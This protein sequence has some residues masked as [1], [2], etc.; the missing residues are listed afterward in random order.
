[1]TA[2]DIDIHYLYI[3]SVDM[4]RALLRWTSLDDLR[5]FDRFYRLRIARQAKCR[6]ED[7][8]TGL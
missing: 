5:S 7:L 6:V 4:I 2:S 3:V 1:M 8:L